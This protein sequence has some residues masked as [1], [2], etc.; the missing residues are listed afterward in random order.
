MYN[1]DFNTPSP[2]TVLHGR[3]RK[4]IRR[5]FFSSGV[6]NLDRPRAGA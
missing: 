5:E 4:I 2:F 6:N 1:R 3:H